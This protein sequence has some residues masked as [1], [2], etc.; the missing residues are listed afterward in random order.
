MISIAK[1]SKDTPPN[2]VEFLFYEYT[3]SIKVFN[4]LQ[5]ALSYLTKF[6]YTP[7]DIQQLIFLKV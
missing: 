3:G 2:E 5:E 6:G 1:K 7:N 4:D